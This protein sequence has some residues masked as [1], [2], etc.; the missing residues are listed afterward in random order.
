ME[1]ITYPNAV[2]WLKDI[3]HT[4]LLS[5]FSP[6]H[7]KRLSTTIQKLEENNI[8]FS[9]SEIDDAFLRWFEGFYLETMG[10]KSNPNPRNIRETIDAYKGKSKCFGLQLTENNVII[11]GAVYIN[12]VNR[13]TTA[14]K[15]LKASWI[16]AKLPVSPSLLAEYILY[17]H[18]KS[19]GYKSISH[20]QD[21]NPYGFNSDIGL[22]SFK[23]SL[24]YKPYTKKNAEVSE[25]DPKSISSKCLILRLPTETGSRA[26]TQADLFIS[27]TDLP[28]MEMLLKYGERL[29]VTTHLI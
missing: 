26:I 2:I 19:H 23:L 20:G 6:R 12:K 5:N 16:D 29:K 27:E 10:D 14:F 8:K 28:S 9:V 22:C 17:T 1:I 25:I 24:G 18:A 15:A 3:D 7:T 21:S 4:D 11:G 13:V